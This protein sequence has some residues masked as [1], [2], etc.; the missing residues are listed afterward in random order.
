VVLWPPGRRDA[1]LVTAIPRARFA[2]V[3]GWAC[4]P[5]VTARLRVERAFPLG[6]AADHRALLEYQQATGAGHVYLTSGGGREADLVLALAARSVK[7]QRL[8]PPEQLRLL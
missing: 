6:E 3:S 8:G 5:E 2:L 1:A 4:D 7:A